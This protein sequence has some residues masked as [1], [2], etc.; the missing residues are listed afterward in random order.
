MVVLSPIMEM[1]RVLHQVVVNFLLRALELGIE[2]RVPSEL[3]EGFGDQIFVTLRFPRVYHFSMEAC[4]FPRKDRAS[5]RGG[6]M[7]RELAIP[8]LK[9]I[10]GGHSL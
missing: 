7:S 4:G 1:L 8:F 3:G 9:F 5:P 6:Q 10:N 2:F